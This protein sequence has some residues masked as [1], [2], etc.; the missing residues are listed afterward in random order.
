[1]ACEAPDRRSSVATDEDARRLLAQFINPDADHRKLTYDL[2]PTRED[3]FAV[4]A[5]DLAPQAIEYYAEFFR[6]PSAKIKP[7]ALQRE[8]LLY[9]ATVEDLKSQNEKAL[10]FPG[11][12]QK[13]AARM[14][15]GIT[16]YKF[17]FVEPGQKFGVTY[18]GLIFVNGHWRMFPKPWRILQ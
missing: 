10:I 16:V 15:P 17:K 4:F 13:I 14:K 2:S 6:N 12:Y 3:C 7:A 8:I 9:S 5:D 1:M 11:G 18:D